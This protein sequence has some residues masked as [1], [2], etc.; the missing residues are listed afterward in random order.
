MEGSP[1]APHRSTPSEIL[2]RRDLERSGVAFVV[3]RDG[4]GAQRTFPLAAGRLVV[5]RRRG[6]DVTLDWDDRVSRAHAV[7]ERIGEEWAIEDAGMSRNGT[8][9][10]GERLTGR[11]VLRGGDLVTVGS[12][13]L[14]Y[15][16]AAG[17]TD[18]ETRQGT[19]QGTLAELTPAQRRVLVALCRPMLGGAA[20]PASNQEIAD[21]LVLGVE[22]V[23]THLKALFE[24]FELEGSAPAAKR[25]ELAQGA[26]RLGL[27][28]ASDL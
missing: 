16:A 3:A 26:I 21:Q 17:D 11:R 22:T 15:V 23:K 6:S 19:V 14:A 9:V 18:A 10:N 2:E 28:S 7:L 5:G 25:V 8:F 12:T 24:R 27:V 13:T 20:T 1:L 4:G